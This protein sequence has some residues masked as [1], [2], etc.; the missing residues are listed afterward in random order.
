M[1]ELRKYK[2]R[3]L[4]LFF[5]SIDKNIHLWEAA[6]N[7][8]Y[9]EE[10]DDTYFKINLYYNQIELKIKKKNDV[11]LSTYKKNLFWGFFGSHLYYISNFKVWWYVRK[12]KNNFNADK[13]RRKNEIILLKSSIEKINNKYVTFN[14]KEKLKKINK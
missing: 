1:G 13:L 2:K 4:K 14:R 11:I 12:V 5:I 3:A 9:S 8:Y 10:F 7:I 6:N